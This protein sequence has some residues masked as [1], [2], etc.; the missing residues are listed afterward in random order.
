[1]DEPLSDGNRFRGCSPKTEASDTV[2]LAYLEMR[3][4]TEGTAE[5]STEIFAYTVAVVEE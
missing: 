2:E 4:T 5:V 3:A 1:M